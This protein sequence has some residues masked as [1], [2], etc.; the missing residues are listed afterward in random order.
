MLILMYLTPLIM[1]SVAAR[2][3]PEIVRRVFRVAYS[4]LFLLGLQGVLRLMLYYDPPIEK[5]F[6]I[7]GTSIYTTV[8]SITFTGTMAWAESVHISTFTKGQIWVIAFVASMVTVHSVVATIFGKFLNQLDMKIKGGFKKEQYIILGD[9]ESARVLIKD[10]FK[11]VDKPYVVFLPTDEL[12]DDDPLYLRCRVEKTDYLEK[13]PKRKKLHIVLLPDTEFS[14]LDRVYLLNE[15]GNSNLHATV[16]LNNDVVRYHDLH[17]DKIDNCTVS[18]DQ[19]LVEHFLTESSPFELMKSRGAFAEGGLP[20]LEE[21]FG[22]C[23]IGFGKIGQEFLMRTYETM[24]FL[25]KDGIP[26]FEALVV[27]KFASVLEQEFVNNAPYF[28]DNKTVEFFQAEVDSEAY[29]DEIGKRMSR[30]HQIVVAIGNTRENVAA[31]LSLCRFFDRLGCYEDRPQIVV[32][33]SDSMVGAESLFKDYPNVK[34]MD[35]NTEIF[36]FEDLIEAKIDSVAKEINDNYNRTSG[37]GKPWR[38]LGTYLQALNRATVCDIRI[39][40]ELNRMCSAPDKERIEFLARYEHER[41]CVFNRSHGWKLLPLDELTQEER[42]NYV[43][44]REQQKLH[45][46]LIPWDE[47]DKLPQRSEGEIR[48]YDVANVEQALAYQ[49]EESEQSN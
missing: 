44:K 3:L 37:R 26:P 45:A 34:M 30:L 31:A 49:P 22:I 39:K 40:K 38:E 14:N 10:I 43:L 5:I 8:Q 1:V 12:K 2:R 33:L 11:C 15:S 16:F 4:F 19:I 47:L 21:T 20:Y 7:F 35:F 36:N 27:D 23:L 46:C 24:C 42:D 29:F 9:T 41:W 13:I 17:I 6:E 32:I 25:T 48:S 28:H 18:V